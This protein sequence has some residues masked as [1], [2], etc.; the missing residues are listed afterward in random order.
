MHRDGHNQA[1]AL[2]A[3]ENRLLQMVATGR[4]LPEILAELCRL[5]EESS[6]GTLASI[7]L[8]STDGR[9]LRHGAA[10]SL[11]RRYTEAI[12]GGEIGPRAGSCGTA[13]YRKEPV[14]AADIETDPLWADYR[15]LAKPHGLRACWSTPIFASD[16]GVLGT[17]AIY[18][19]EPRR[20]TAQDQQL[21]RQTTH[22]ASV[23]IE[24]RRTE[25]A[26]HA[27]ERL[28]RGQVEALTN[29]LAAMA[30][31]SEPD[32]FLEHVL[33]TIIEQTSAH[34]IAAW[35][36]NDDSRRFDMIAV[37]EEGRYETRAEATH[38]GRKLSM[39]PEHH[40]VWREVVR[41]GQYGIMD[42]IDKE[43][44]RM[45][46][47]SGDWHRMLE[48]MNPDPSFTILLNHLREMG[49]R[50]VLFVPI[51]IA[52]NVAGTLAIRFQDRRACRREEIE[53][54][55]ALA[56]QAMLAI[57]LMRLSR[58][59]RQA[60]VMAERN[61]MARDIHDTLAQG[62]TGVIMQLEAATGA[63]ERNDLAEVAGHIERAG[64]L[65]RSSLAE[66]RRSV[67]ALRLP[68]LQAGKLSL[69][70][71]H[72]LKCMTDGSRLHA[73]F[74]ADGEEQ[75]LGAD[76]EETLLRITQE[77]LTNTIKHAQAR[78]FRATLTVGEDKTQ[79][80][81]VDDGCGFDPQ[82]DHEG[83]G[84]TG[85]KERVD[86]MSGRFIVRSKP[87]QGSEIVVVLHNP[88]AHEQA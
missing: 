82:A 51:L 76:G 80:Q 67:R 56:H 65:A 61:R 43:S 41:T 14:V 59:S 74:H 86:R 38:P 26:L 78:N 24:R 4:A 79:L 45:C 2:L 15:H 81:L 63:A 8:V 34:S 66:A 44:A 36:R 75:R 58:E 71:D 16:G 25:E 49:V 3:G 37:I 47:G 11:P 7:L 17:F 53:L 50:T 60:A 27:S 42:D 30:R 20:P 13:A 84:L 52:G 87:G 55:R 10:P 32:Q 35:A 54:T 39:L 12:D 5:C 85:M 19:R 21:I 77:A 70:I 40:P 6:S 9:S 46:V 31:E 48:D 33:R 62:F 72:L 64:E 29:T 22:L 23:A 68:S 28:A 83:F 18:W 1:E 73:E 88:N 57:Q 69:A